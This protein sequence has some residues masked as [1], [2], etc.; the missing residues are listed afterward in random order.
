MSI[1]PSVIIQNIEDEVLPNSSNIVQNQAIYSFLEDN[2]G[3]KTALEKAVN[4]CLGGRITRFYNEGIITL[5]NHFQAQ[6]DSLSK[7]RA[8]NCITIEKNAFIFCD[9][10]QTVEAKQVRNVG[11]GAFA[12]CERLNTIDFRYSLGGVFQT[13]KNL[14]EYAPFLLCTSLLNVY[15]GGEVWVIENDVSAYNLFKPAITAHPSTFK[16]YVPSAKASLYRTDPQWSTV[17]SYIYTF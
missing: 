3:A 14:G 12:G 4:A 15:L 17:S 9:H 10:L 6:R 2:F 8:N 16:I 5:G 11:V 13:P 7:I 1:S